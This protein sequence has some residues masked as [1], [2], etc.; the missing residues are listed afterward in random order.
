MAFDTYTLRMLLKEHG[1]DV[2]LRK[3]DEGAYNN[4]TG[5]ISTVNTD[6]TVRAYFYDFNADTLLPTSIQNGERRVVL[7]ATLPNGSATPKPNATDQIINGDVLDVVKVFEVK[8][9]NNTLFYTLTVR[10]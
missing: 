3:V 5:T 7:S 10:D 9:G 4:D 2:V 8:S 1:M 6:Y